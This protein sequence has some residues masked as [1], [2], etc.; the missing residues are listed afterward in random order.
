METHHIRRILSL[1]QKYQVWVLDREKVSISQYLPLINIF[2]AKYKEELEKKPYRFNLLDDLKTDENA[3]SRVLTRILQYQPAFKSFIEYVNNNSNGKF[4]FDTKKI[5]NP[6]VTAEKLRIDTLIRDSGEYAVIIENK[7][8]GASDRDR[9]IEHYIDKCKYLGYKEEN[10]Y[11]FYLTRDNCKYEKKYHETWGKYKDSESFNKHYLYISYNECILPWITTFQSEIK[12]DDILLESA[13]T[14]YIDHLNNNEI[15]K[16]MDAELQ[17][18]LKKELGLN[19][20]LSSNISEIESKI[21]DLDKLQYQLKELLVEEQK[22]IFRDCFEILKDKYKSCNLISDI[23][24]K[25]PNGFMQV[26]IRTCYN[27]KPFVIF[28]EYNYKTIYYGFGR[29]FASDEIDSDL[30]QSLQPFSQKN[31]LRVDNDLWWYA[32]KYTSFEDGFSELNILIDS[33]LSDSRL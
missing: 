18:F 15:D 4:F 28:L 25:Y 33:F 5:S 9:Q 3:H 7:I 30:K 1:S 14:Q 20:S 21:E 16:N 22:A 10:I 13:I 17:N 12:E 26:G 23:I 11:V 6:K 32:W 24:L 2:S 27:N 19:K 8:H 31:N 29:H